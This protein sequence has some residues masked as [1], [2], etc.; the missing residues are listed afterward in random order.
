MKSQQNLK[1]TPW[2]YTFRHTNVIFINQVLRYFFAK[3]LKADLF[4]CMIIC[5][6]SNWCW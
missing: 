1:T 6:V 4:T 3:T 5:L 2:K